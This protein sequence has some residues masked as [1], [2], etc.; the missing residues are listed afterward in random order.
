MP[1][2]L[3]RI[4]RP[5]VIPEGNYR[6]VTLLPQRFIT[7]ISHCAYGISMLAFMTRSELMGRKDVCR[8]WKDWK[9]LI[10]LCLQEFQRLRGVPVILMQIIINFMGQSEQLQKEYLGKTK[11]VIPFKIYSIVSMIIRYLIFLPISYHD[12]FKRLKQVL[13]F[14][15]RIFRNRKDSKNTMEVWR[16]NTAFLLN[17]QWAKLLGNSNKCDR[18]ENTILD[19]G[20]IELRIIYHFSMSLGPSNCTFKHR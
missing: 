18:S 4:S 13:L 17:L 9:M 20:F 12:F 6:N 15:S 11:I 5:G 8:I 3:G 2:Q 1:N 7:F 16:S 14:A 19:N 10:N